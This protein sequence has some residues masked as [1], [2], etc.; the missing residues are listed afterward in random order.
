MKIT[1]RAVPAV[2]PPQVMKSLPLPILF[3]PKALIRLYVKNAMRIVA[4]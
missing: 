4:I 2:M 1:K 3:P